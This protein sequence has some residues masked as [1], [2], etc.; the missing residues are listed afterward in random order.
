MGELQYNVEMILRSATFS[1]CASSGDKVQGQASQEEQQMLGFQNSRCCYLKAL[2]CSFR[3]NEL[4]V[5]KVF[6]DVH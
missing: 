2:T 6:H 5:F 1:V 4:S 3:I